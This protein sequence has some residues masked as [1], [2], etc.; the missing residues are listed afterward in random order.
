MEAQVEAYQGV[1]EAFPGKKVVVRT[2]DAGADKPLPFLTDATEANPALGVRAYRTTRRD[3]EVLDHQLEALAKA[4][5]ATEAKGLGH[6]PD[7]L[8]GRGG[9]GLHAEGPLLRSEERPG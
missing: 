7:D 4:E 3:P 2:L 8:H 5:A 9:R 6:G 1:L